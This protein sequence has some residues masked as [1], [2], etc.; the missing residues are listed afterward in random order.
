MQGCQAWREGSTGLLYWE[1]A[2]SREWQEPVLSASFSEAFEEDTEH[3]LN[4]LAG[5]AK[6]GTVS[7][8]G[9]NCHLNGSRPGGE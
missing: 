4:K 7:T 3:V 5:G 9:Q 8:E 2:A 6:A 1:A